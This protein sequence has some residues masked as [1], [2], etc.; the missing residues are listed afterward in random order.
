MET[1]KKVLLIQ[2]TLSNY[3]EPIYEII[4]KHVDLTLA[5]VVDNQLI[6]NSF[7]VIKLPYIKISK[8]YY[9]THLI[10]ICNQYDVVIILP[11]LKLIRLLSL[12]FY[13]RHFK[14][15]T[16][17]IGVKASYTYIF[18][19]T[20]KP[21]GFYGLL[22]MYLIKKSDAFIFYMEATANYWLKY[23]DVPKEKMFVAHNTVAVH[24]FDK[25]PVYSKRNT[26]LFIGT[27]YKQ[28]GI[29]ELLIAYKKAYSLEKK[30]PKLLIIGNGPEFD[31]IISFI[32]EHKLI[33]QVEVLGAIFDEA[34]LME[35]FFHS[36]LCVSPTQAGLSVLKSMGYGVP[37]V[38]RIDSITGG[39]RLNI[40]NGENGILYNNQDDLTNIL[41]EIIRNPE[42]FKKM[43]TNAREYYI[44]YATPEKMAQGAL[45]AINYVIEKNK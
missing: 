23:I 43:S 13:K 22:Y 39:E 15:I 21:H 17:S 20:N 16:W 28:K 4:S 24:P 27:L 42:K 11:H 44:N 38:T 19:I 7:S 34:I 32:S 9:N 35:H 37:F 41:I 33:N 2:E 40:I 5:Y 10:K 14:V 8:L 31:S 18:S 45:D 29:E 26:I 6:N 3:R 25:L 30:I 12:P 36:I 1:R